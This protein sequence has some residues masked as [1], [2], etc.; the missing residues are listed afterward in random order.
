LEKDLRVATIIEEATFEDILNIIEG[1]W[2]LV[3]NNYMRTA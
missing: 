2:V 3:I 1:I